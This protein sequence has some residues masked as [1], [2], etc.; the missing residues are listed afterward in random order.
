MPN[1]PYDELLKNLMK[2]LEQI[3]SL[4]KNMQKMQEGGEGRPG[5][6]GCAIITGNLAHAGDCNRNE[7]EKSGLAY[8]MVDAGDVAY[9]TI[10][11]PGGLAEEP[12]IHLQERACQIST[13]GLSGSIDLTFSIIPESSSW[14]VSNGVLDMVLVKGASPGES[15][16]DTTQIEED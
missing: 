2:L 5:I 15:V 4:E 14:S 1:N 6:I 3:T 11:L 10:E 8:E 13:C 7:P 12:R 9:L 16:P